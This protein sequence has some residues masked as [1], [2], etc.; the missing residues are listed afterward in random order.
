MSVGTATVSGRRIAITADC[1]HR[2]VADGVHHHSFTSMASDSNPHV[3]QDAEMSMWDDPSFTSL[4]DNLGTSVESPF[5]GSRLFDMNGA[6][7]VESPNYGIKN[8]FEEESGGQ[9]H[10]NQPF[11]TRS[12]VS[13]RSAESSSQ[14]SA[15]ETS[16]RKRQNTSATSESPPATH[17]HFKGV[18]REYDGSQQLHTNIE[19]THMPSLHSLQSFGRS[20][21]NLSL[22]PDFVNATQQSQMASNFDFDSAASSPGASMDMTDAAYASQIQASMN[23]PLTAASR[24]HHDPPVSSTCDLYLCPSYMLC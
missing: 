19:G 21:H 23:R 14:D 4:Y 24:K 7:S 18:K 16:G 10:Q 8:T 22:D 12:L 11:H 2:T 17:S 20:M 1:L 15:S 5:D 3:V 13:S 6:G 9:N